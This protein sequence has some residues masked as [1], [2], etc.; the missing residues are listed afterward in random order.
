MKLTNEFKAALAYVVFLTLCICGLLTFRME[1][2]RKALDRGLIQDQHGHW[3]N[4]HHQD[5]L[6]RLELEVY[7][8][9]QRVDT[10]TDSGSY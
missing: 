10:M 6:S 3:V 4:A 1:V 2:E 5:A 9:K 8:L 7:R